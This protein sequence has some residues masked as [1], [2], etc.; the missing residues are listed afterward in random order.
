MPDTNVRI[1]APIILE[2][3]HK[4]LWCRDELWDAVIEDL[5]ERDPVAAQKVQ[6]TLAR[7]PQLLYS[8]R[9]TSYAAWAWS[10]LDAQARA[11]WIWACETTH[12]LWIRGIVGNR[13]ALG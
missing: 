2:R 11:D 7:R 9:S 13:V 1:Q 8:G 6:E 12:E 5:N 4:A 10:A 3:V